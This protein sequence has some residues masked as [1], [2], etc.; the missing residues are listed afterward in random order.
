MHTKQWDEKKRFTKRK[1][2]DRLRFP[3]NWLKP[4]P[5]HKYNTYFLRKFRDYETQETLGFFISFLV[6]K[7]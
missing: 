1:I 5:V 6:I 4:Q 3:V 2:I 7:V